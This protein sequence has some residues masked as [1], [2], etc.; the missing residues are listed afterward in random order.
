MIFNKKKYPLTTIAGI[1]GILLYCVFIFISA[2]LFASSWTPIDNFISDFGNSS[3]SYN[4]KGAIF[5]NLG[6]I[7]LGTALIFYYI[8]LYK[9]SGEL[10]TEY[11]EKILK[12]TQIV[13]FFV[14]VFLIFFG[15]SYSPKFLFYG[16]PLLI[17]YSLG[18]CM[19]KENLKKKWNKFALLFTQIVGILSGFFAITVG[20]FSTDFTEAHIFTSRLFFNTHLIAFFLIVLTLLPHKKFIK[21]VGLYGWIVANLIFLYLLFQDPIFEWIAVF[22]SLSFAGLISYNTYKAFSE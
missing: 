6:I 14:G 9:W 7:I 10:K 12:I 22:T 17:F 8:G 11:N 18:L 2:S 16:F 3:S 4:P 13:G 20:I 19:R 5:C 21:V 15:F 1:L